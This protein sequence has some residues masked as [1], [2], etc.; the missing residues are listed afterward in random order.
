MNK[1]GDS[2]LVIEAPTKLNLFLH[3]T[4]Q[5]PDGYHLLESLFAFTRTG[6]RIKIAASDKLSLDVSGPFAKDIDSP[7]HDNLVYRAVKAVEKHVGMAI[8]A[9]IHLEKNLPVA[10]GI[11]GGSS[12]AAATLVGLNACFNLGITDAELYEIAGTLGA[13]VPACLSKRP[14]FVTGIGDLVRPTALTFAGHIVLVNPGLAVSTPTIFKAFHDH[15]LDFQPSL[16]DAPDDAWTSIE[17]LMSKTVNSLQPATIALV[18]E[19]QNCID[20][21]AEAEGCKIV[22]MSGSGATCF[23]LFRAPEEA[24]AAAKVVKSHHPEWWVRVDQLVLA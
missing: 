22:R 8:Q 21:L 5:R 2:C 18:P 23:G 3:I 20:V 6:D 16:G 12:D 1:Q 19:V 14:Q 7:V 13:D 10:A 11:G 24:E 17:A 4:G 9:H 15:S